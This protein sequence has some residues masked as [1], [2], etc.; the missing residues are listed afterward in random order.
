ML[1]DYAGENNLFNIVHHGSKLE[2]AVKSANLDLD[3]GVIEIFYNDNTDVKPQN[4]LYFQVLNADGTVER[5][6]IMSRLE[7]LEMTDNYIKYKIGLIKTYYD[8]D[9]EDDNLS[10]LAGD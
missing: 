2:E 5:A 9:D 3:N 4:S 8:L 7:V 10:G 6:Y 1:F